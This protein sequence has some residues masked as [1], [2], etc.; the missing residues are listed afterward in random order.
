LMY[1]IRNPIADEPLR[2]KTH[3]G[4]LFGLIAVVAIVLLLL[5]AVVGAF[6]L[7]LFPVVAAVVLWFLKPQLDKQDWLYATFLALIAGVTGLGAEWISFITPVQW[8]FLQVPLTLLSFLA[9]WSILRRF[10]LLQQGVGCS[11]FLT[12]GIWPAV[13]SFLLGILL[14]TPW[15]LATVV[16]GSAEG[17]RSA[18]VESWWQPLIAL[19]PGIAEEAWGRLFLVPLAFLLFRRVSPNRTAFSTALIV[20]AY[21]FAY[22]HV[23]GNALSVLVSTFII[24]SLFSLPI[25]IV[26]LYYDLETAIGFH[27]WMDFLKFAS[28]L[29]LFNR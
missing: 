8:G 20:M 4:R 13:R 16:M 19:Q 21:W 12:T 15:A 11:R 27:F 23:S 14:G 9:G 25:S 7:F 28:A 22:L 5:Q 26:C 17:G 6:I 1:L 18:W 24:G 10:G 3:K 29:V 2:P